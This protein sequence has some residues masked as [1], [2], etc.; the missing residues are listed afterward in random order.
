MT[1]L[2]DTDTVIHLM[3]GLSIT[4]PHTEKQK[5][6]HRVGEH[7]FN[8]C[9]SLSAQGKVIALSAITVAELEYGANGATDPSA[10]RKKMRRF[11]APFALLDFTVEH[12]TV[13]YGAIRALLE[14]S[15]KVIGPNDLLIAAHARGI[16]AT[17]VTHNTAE[18]RR[19]PGLTAVDWVLP[20]S[21]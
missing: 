15:G 3:R 9:R 21:K 6:R 20:A 10:E 2:L 17:L 13:H 1:Y 18:C 4:N 19:V 7:I 8:K 11:L 5:H 14:S 12:C 16:G